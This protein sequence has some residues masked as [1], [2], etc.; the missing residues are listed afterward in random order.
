MVSAPILTKKERKKETNE[1]NGIPIL[2]FE[3]EARKFVVEQIEQGY[4]SLTTI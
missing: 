2:F 1:Q 3:V 4:L